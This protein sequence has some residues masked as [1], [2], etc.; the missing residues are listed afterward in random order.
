MAGVET[1]ERERERREVLSVLSAYP[2][3]VGTQQSLS[4]ERVLQKN[5][6]SHITLQE[7][8]HCLQ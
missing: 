7:K 1:I 4:L 8:A 2:I 6:V 5:A 3:Y